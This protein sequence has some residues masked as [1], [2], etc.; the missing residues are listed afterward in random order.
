MNLQYSMRDIFKYGKI[1]F[2]GFKSSIKYDFDSIEKELAIKI[3]SGIKQFISEEL[4]EPVKYISYISESFRSN[5]SSTIIN[6]ID[7]YPQRNLTKEEEKMFYN[8]INENQNFKK[9]YC[10]HA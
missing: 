3:L 10:L 1:N 8:F 9:I 2:K 5:R 7:K 6:Y 4:K